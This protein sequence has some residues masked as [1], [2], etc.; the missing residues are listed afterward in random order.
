MNQKSN[1]NRLRFILGKLLAIVTRHD[2]YFP[3]IEWSKGTCYTHD[4]FR[5]Y[6]YLFGRRFGI[7]PESSVQVNQLEDGTVELY[8]KFF[9]VEAFLSHVEF[10]VRQNLP[11]K[12]KIEINPVFSSVILD[13]FGFQRRFVGNNGLIDNLGYRFAIAFDAAQED[14]VASGASSLTYAATCTGSDRWLYVAVT[15]ISDATHSVTGFT[16][17]AV[18]M[19]TVVA[20]RLVYAGTSWYHHSYHLPAPAS[21]SNNVVITKSNADGSIRSGC[22]SYSGV[23]QTTPVSTSAANNGTNT[24][25]TVSLT[26]SA[27]A[28]WL[29]SGANI[30]AA[31]AGSTNTDTLR[32]SYGG[33]CD[34]CDSGNDISPQTGNATMTFAGTREWGGI[35]L[36]FIPSGASSAVKTAEGLAIAS[37]KTGLGLAT[38][39]VKNWQ[40]LA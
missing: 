17:N 18:S 40:G 31:F 9:T 39:S 19:T 16:Y 3:D 21:G 10:V 23:D 13:L 27:T 7:R 5:A 4:V 24:P 20:N 2:R 14:K 38:A 1:M 28:W 34:I 8:R 33:L 26:T 32:V 29:F 12:P 36:A 15:T 37:V 22:V 6:E 35:A 30:D 11:K 25:A